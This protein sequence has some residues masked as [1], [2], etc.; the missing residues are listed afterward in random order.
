MSIITQDQIL[1]YLEQANMLEVS[2]L[3]KTIQERFNISDQPLYAQAP[4]PA[5]IEE[6]VEEQTEFTVMLV[7]HGPERVAVIKALRSEVGLGLLEG[8]EL[9]N[10]LPQPIKKDVSRGIA[11]TLQKIFE[12]IG[13]KVEIK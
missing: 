4:P 12:D 10:T 6:K 9:I 11:E 13:A 3:I 7:D 2:A 5:P 8:K 1:E